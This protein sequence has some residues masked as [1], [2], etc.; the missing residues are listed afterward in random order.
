[1]ERRIKNFE[2]YAITDNGK[3]ISYKSK[4]PLIMKT[5]LDRNGYENIKLCKG[6]KTYHFLVHRLVAEHFINNPN[7]LSDVDHRDKNRRNNV[8]SNL[9]WV[10]HRQNIINS[11]DT[12]S[13]VRNYIP[14]S[15]YSPNGK[16][17]GKYES[18]KE[19]CRQAEKKYKTSFT[20]MYRNLKSKGYYII[21]E[22]DL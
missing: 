16:F 19:C 1:M 4:K 5:F 18:V 17:L 20:G 9:R 21:K 15:L 12:L 3:V 7:N 13:P 14:C 8:V 10:S 22:N 2:D 6:N 11:Y